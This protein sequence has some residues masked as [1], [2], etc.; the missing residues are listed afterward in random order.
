[1]LPD[2]FRCLLV[3]RDQAGEVRQAI[4]RRPTAELPAG[5]V[6]VRVDY[7]SLNYKDALAATGH[8]GVNKTF[9]HV[10]GVDAAGVVADS[11]VYEFVAGDRVLVTGFDMGSNRWGGY[12]E[13][14]RVPSEWLVPMPESLSP[15]ES[16][17]LGTG[18]LTAA[19]MVDALQKHDVA[20]DSGEVAVTGASGGVGCLAV[21]ILARLGYRVSAVSGKPQAREFLTA[22]GAAEVLGREAVDDTSDRPLLSGRWAGA[23]DTVGGNTLGTLLRTTKHGG[24]VAAC[25]LARSHELPIT[26][27]PFILRGVTLAG[28]D[29]AYPPPALRHELWQRLAGPWKPAPL[30]ELARTVSLDDLA[31]EFPAIL[32]GQVMGRVVVAI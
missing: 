25:G 30:A 21:A 17:A 4:A 15:W 16:M 8:P 7:S 5:E 12:A 24:C 29:A 31:A 19:L 6:V 10:P 18:G 27:Y 26:V 28:I 11:G 22:L 1:M 3:T 2:D 13:L 14:V 23:I 9:P 20:P 32:S